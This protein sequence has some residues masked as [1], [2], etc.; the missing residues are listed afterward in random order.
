PSQS[1][2]R[3]GRTMNLESP[4]I[5][6]AK[7]MLIA[8]LDQRYEYDKTSEIPAQWGRFAPH[9]GSIPGQVGGVCYGV[10]HEM[11]KT[12]FRYLAGVDVTSADGLPEGFSILQLPA[13]RYAVFP[14]REHVSKLS[15]TCGAIGS[16]WLPQSGYEAVDS[17]V[18]L[19]RYGEGFDPRTGMGD[20]EVWLPIKG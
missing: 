9:I 15:E 16:Q 6:D 4:R 19:E 10:S 2:S 12:G 1:P 3:G 5:V 8:G 18:M 13:Q 14:H 17:P 11:D 7:P 20:V